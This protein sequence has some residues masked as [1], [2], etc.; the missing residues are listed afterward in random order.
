MKSNNPLRKT[1]GIIGGGQLG[2]MMIEESLRLNNEFNILDAADCPCAPLAKN[3]IIGKLTDG[4]AIKQLAAVSDV[5]TYEIEHIDVATLLQLE[6]KGHEIIPSPKVLQVIQDKGL[7]KQFFA[8]NNIPTSEFRLVETP[9]QWAAAITE[10][11]GSKIVAKTRKDGYDGKGVTILNSADILDDVSKIPFTQPSLLEAYI[12]CEKE[13]SVMV[14]RDREGNT[15]LWPVVEM[16]FDPV[17]NLVTFLDCPATLPENITQQACE[18]ALHTIVQF[19]GIGVF[20]V[21]LF[22]TASGQI[23][24][25]EVAPRPHNSGHHTIEACYTSQFEQLVRILMGLPLGSTDLIQPAVMMN[26]LGADD[27]SG[28]YRLQG[29]EA[30]SALPGV[31]VHLYGKKESKP[32]RKMGHITV[33]APTLEQAKQTAQQVHQLVRFVAD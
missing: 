33:I 23:L 20:A 2:R 29:L 25:N 27:F 11:G 30:A 15:K 5:L 12:P 17:A 7:Q 31:Y 19:Q 26:L 32:V 13:I 28:R 10:I 4:E 16:V 14:A 21:E 3:H 24:V 9:E 22:L 18:V 6:N 8:A 1:I